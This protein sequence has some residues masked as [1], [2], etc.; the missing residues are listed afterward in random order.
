[1][2]FRPSCGGQP[3][4][5]CSGVAPAVHTGSVTGPVGVPPAA[6]SACT[7]VKQRGPAVV[8]STLGTSAEVP[9]VAGSA[10]GGAPVDR[11]VTM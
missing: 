11:T 3:G 7:T 4:C 5:I 10:D 6:A 9:I 1:M 2:T 8:P